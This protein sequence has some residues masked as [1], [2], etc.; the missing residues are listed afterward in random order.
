MISLAELL[1]L[2][3]TNKSVYEIL[4]TFF[5]RCYYFKRGQPEKTL[6]LLHLPTEISRGERK[7]TSLAVLKSEFFSL[8]LSYHRICQV[9]STVP[10]ISNGSVISVKSIIISY[11]V[12]LG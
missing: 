3:K 12:S 10:L 4:P 8:I 2:T 7:L 1:A 9:K 5:S 6:N 11:N